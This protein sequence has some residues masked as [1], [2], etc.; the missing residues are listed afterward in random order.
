MTGTRAER[1]KITLF[2]LQAMKQQNRKITMLSIP[3]YPMALLADRAGLDTILVGDSL[4]MTVLGYDTTVPVTIEEMLHHTKAVTRATKYAFVVGDMP[5]MS[6]NTSERD[7]IINAG[8]FMQEGG[9][10]SVKVEGGANAAH[11]VTAI[12]KAGIPVM[13]HIGLTPQHISLLGGYRVQGR[14]VQTARRVIDDALAIEEAGA[15]AIILE[16]VPNQISKIVTERLRIPTISYG[17][18]ESCDG[19]GLVA[20]DILGMFDKFT[21]KFVKKYAELGEQIQEAFEAYVSDVV[22]GQFPTDGHS[23]HINKED[24]EKVMGQV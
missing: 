16:C 11:I 2:D 12:V 22:S 9:T 20:H 24:L 5:F 21:P 17:A 6:N 7:A 13:G 19:Q 18:G 1:K 10:D 3:D 15:F 23:F 14:D 4:A 8:R